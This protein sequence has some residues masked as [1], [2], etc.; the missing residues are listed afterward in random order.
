MEKFNFPSMRD[1]SLTPKYLFSLHKHNTHHHEKN[2]IDFHESHVHKLLNMRKK[3]I[4]LFF[5]PRAREIELVRAMK[6]RYLST[7][8]IYSTRQKYIYFLRKK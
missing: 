3:N 8:W 5:F 2:L 6:K 1:F 4:W 7:G